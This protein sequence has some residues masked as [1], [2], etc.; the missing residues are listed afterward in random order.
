MKSQD[1]KARAK[2]QLIVLNS[3]H[4]K[5]QVDSYGVDLIW[6]RLSWSGTVSRHLLFHFHFVFTE[7]IWAWF[8]IQKVPD[9]NWVVVGTADDLEVIKLQAKYPSSVLLQRQ[10]FCVHE[11]M[12]IQCNTQMHTQT[13]HKDIPGLIQ[14]QPVS[15]VRI[16]GQNFAPDHVCC[17]LYYKMDLE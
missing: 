6:H 10:Q 7:D 2:L 16:D 3:M 15:F 1:K 11:Y 4:A 13:N 17:K 8:W 9:E 14:T 5:G 12:W